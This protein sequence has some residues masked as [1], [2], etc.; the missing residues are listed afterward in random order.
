MKTLVIYELVPEETKFYILDG[1]RSDLNGHFIN[2]ADVPSELAEELSNAWEGREV[3]APVVLDP[4][5]TWT[6]V[7]CGFIL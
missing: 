1:D 3:Q 2:G 4:K 7:I 5:E 6:V